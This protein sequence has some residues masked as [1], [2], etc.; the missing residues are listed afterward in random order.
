MRI[1]IAVLLMLAPV[2]AQAQGWG[3]S[4]QNL[5]LVVKQDDG[6]KSVATENY[7]DGYTAF[8][9]RVGGWVFVAQGTRYLSV[10][11]GP[12]VAVSLGERFLPGLELALGAGYETFSEKPGDTGEIHNR[13]AG[14]VKITGPQMLMFFDRLS[15]EGYYENGYDLNTDKF[16]D[17]WYQARAAL[18]MSDRIAASFYGQTDA[19]LG[20]RLDLNV[21]IKRVVPNLWVS[22][23][24]FGRPWEKGTLLIGA[25]LSFGSK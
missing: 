15:V 8:S 1:F 6:K 2:A 20:P 24:V 19:G 17:A 7:M 18:R 10:V 11:G 16:R 22:R 13:F 5:T 4:F 23:A 12:Y 25:D 9:D 21:P 3:M 14:N